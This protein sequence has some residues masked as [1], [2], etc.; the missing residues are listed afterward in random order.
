MSSTPLAQN[1]TVV[2]HNTKHDY[3]VD[4]P[5]LVRLAEGEWVATVT[6]TPRIDCFN[7]EAL[8]EQRVNGSRAHIVRSLDD[9]RTW[10][11]VAELPYYAATPWM[12]D[13]S[14]YLFVNKGGRTIRNDDFLLLRSDDGGETWSDPVTL[15]EGHFWNC[16]TSMVV[17]GDRLY[18]A[19]DDLSLGSDARGP[20]VV[21]GDLSRDPMDPSAWRMSNSVPYPGN[22]GQLVHPKFMDLPSRYL[23]PNVLD[24]AG[25]LRV[26]A[27]VKQNRQSTT[28]LCAVFDVTDDGENVEFSFTQYHPMPGGQLKFDI[29]WDE[30]S[31]LFWCALN[32]AADGQDAYGW[33]A[34]EGRPFGGGN[35]RRFLMLY[36]GLD[37]LNWFPAGCVARAGKLSQSFMYPKLVV[38]G[39][40][41]GIISR[42]SINAPNRHDADYATFHRM[43]GFRDLAMNLRPE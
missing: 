11:P 10:T 12:H 7:E 13:G 23:E 1:Y 22:P 2:Y 28:G 20:C 31:Q 8:G 3:F 41:I 30:I 27:T 38:D 21:A 43:R 29:V 36:Y 6:V 26:L 15:F 34:K 9:G 32:L 24:V 40:D 42:S 25:R 18:W 35:D 39:D 16:H 33:Q 14:L 37:G 5:G 19:T 4:G 17:R